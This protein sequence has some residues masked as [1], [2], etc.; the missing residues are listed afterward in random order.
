MTLSIRFACLTFCLLS[1][2]LSL[3]NDDDQA[4]PKHDHAA[5]TPQS[6][7]VDDDAGLQQYADIKTQPLVSSTIQPEFVAYGVVLG[8]EPLLALRQQYLAA[9]AL[10]DSAAA[11]YQ[12]ADA[13][14]S[15]TRSLHQSDIV[16]TR[17][18][19]EQQAQW[20]T[21]KANLATSSYQQQTILASGRLQWGDTLTTWFTQHHG[22]QAERFLNHRAQLL[23]ITLPANTSLPPGLKSL[24]VGT[25]GRRDLAIRATLI[26][27]AP[28]VD[29][30]TQGERYFFECEGHNL[31]FGAYL[32]AWIPS[33]SPGKTGVLIPES[34]VVWHLGQAHIFIKT[35]EGQFSR[36]TLTELV[37]DKNGYFAA[38]GFE[39][40]E[41]I[42]ITGA[43]TLLS[44]Q[45]KNL[46]P[47]EDK[48]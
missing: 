16:S 19:Q 9:Q 23:Q 27:Q 13:N 33:G 5:Q 8:L 26:S 36:R 31:P 29:P 20:Q 4:L 37:P 1:A 6:P 41:E 38:A 48:D 47:N 3:A 40:G 44:D 43:Q 46:I 45:L 17:R 32:N 34:A 22:K 25:Q 18:L 15:R 2:P 42:V 21:D 12:E 28:Q 10:Q 24:A 7:S 30:I 11:K 39:P 35:A 14:L